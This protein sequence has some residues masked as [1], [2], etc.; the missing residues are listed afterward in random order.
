VTHSRV[1][2]HG[3]VRAHPFENLGCLDHPVLAYVRIDVAAAEEHRRVLEIVGIVARSA[4][5]ANE[6]TAE[7]DNAAVPPC[8]TRGKLEGEARALREA[9][10]HNLFRWD[11]GFDLRQE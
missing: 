6:P 8:M 1:Q 3:H 4:V 11:G 2:A 7:T 10:E 5:R 9:Q